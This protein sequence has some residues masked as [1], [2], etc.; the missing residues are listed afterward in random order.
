MTEK[1]IASQ[2]ADAEFLERMFPFKRNFMRVDNWHVHYADEGEGEIVML[3]H[4]CPQWSFSFRRL[5]S[6]LSRKYR[7]I[8]PD[9]LGF[10]LSDKPEDFDYMLNSYILILEEFIQNLGLTRINIVGHGWGGTVA[11]GFAVEPPNMISSLIMMNSIAF[12][13]YSIP[14]RLMICRL[15]L[16]G[17]LLTV[18][19][20][21]MQSGGSKLPPDVRK[22]YAL[23]LS[24]REGRYPLLRYVESIPS[25]PESDT[26]QAILAIE[27]GLWM[28]RTKPVR[29]IWAMKDWLYNQNALRLWHK[30]IPNAEIHTIADAGRYVLEEAPEELERLITEFLEKNAVAQTDAM[31]VKTGG[32]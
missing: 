11:M 27:A 23:P 21:A 7:V 3:F 1:E 15:P 5:I 12:S 28:F 18:Y 22:A 31:P 10:G 19:F 8:A 4:A 32:K 2:K 24:G 30:N 26:V 13:H 16:L 14:L 17:P 6:S 25:V 9:L 20:K 29:I